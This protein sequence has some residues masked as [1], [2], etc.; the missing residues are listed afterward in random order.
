MEL[1]II[2]ILIIF[3]LALIFLLFWKFWFLRDPKRKIPSGDNLVSPADG[4]INEIIRGNKWKQKINKGLMGKVNTLAKE[5]SQEYYLVNIVM[6]PFDVHI[7]RAPIAGKVV[8]VKHTPGKFRNAVSKDIAIDNEKNEILIEGKIR[9]K[10]IQ[11]AGAF[12]RR[13]NCFVKKN[14]KL[15]KGERVGL[16]N[17]GSQVSLILPATV[18]LRIKKG[19]KIKAGETIIGDFRSSK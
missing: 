17:L 15:N 18:N 5:I 14:Q 10:V 16:I 3:A 11:I 6:T 4:M 9:L 13:I 8:K 7:Q 19:Q 12:A 1:L 2:F